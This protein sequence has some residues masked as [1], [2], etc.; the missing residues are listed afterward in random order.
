MQVE[1]EF[2]VYRGEGDDEEEIELTIVGDVE[3]YVPAN[4]SGHPDTWSPPEGGSACVEGIL[5]N[6]EPW[7]GKLTDKETKEAETMLYQALEDYEP[8]P[9]SGYDD[10]ID[11][12][13]AD[14]YYDPY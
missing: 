4:L 12:D 3:P 14:Y 8:E 11:D 9:D 1:I 2:Y 6:G 13:R 5:L 7:S 10:Y